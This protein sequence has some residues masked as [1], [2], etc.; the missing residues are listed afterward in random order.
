MKRYLNGQ[1]TAVGLA[2]CLIAG[3]ATSGMAQEL[4][5]KGNFSGGTVAFSAPAGFSNYQL[6][7]TGPNGFHA[8]ASSKKGAPAINLRSLGI[9][10]DGTYNYQLSAA[11]TERAPVRTPTN[12]GRGA[13]ENTELLVGASSSGSFVVKGGGIVQPTAE[14]E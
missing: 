6:T 8:T 14:T 10:D 5:A 9:V 1:C 3:F 13:Q 2:A 4:S 11:S 7:V 12:N